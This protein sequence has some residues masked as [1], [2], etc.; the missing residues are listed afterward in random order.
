MN[1]RH[2]FFALVGV[3]GLS[4]VLHSGI[5]VYG[6]Y[7]LNLLLAPPAPADDTYV[8][9]AREN[10]RLFLTILIALSSLVV[11]YLVACF[12]F[13]RNASWAKY[14]WLLFSAAIAALYL[15]SLASGVAWTK[16]LSEFV[17]SAL[18]CWYLLRVRK[19]ANAG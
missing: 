18:S 1:D 17:L 5:A 2:A 9:W 8:R 6:F 14:I 19:R 7:H 12:G 11:L 3:L 4:L 10:Y 15:V 16:H 13:V